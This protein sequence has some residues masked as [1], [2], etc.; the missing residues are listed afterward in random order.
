MVGAKD[1]ETN[2]VAARAIPKVDGEVL[3]DF[4]DSV[5]DPDATVYT[6]GSSAYRRRDNHES[7][8][9]SHGEYVPGRR[10]HE[11]RGVAV[12]DPEASL[13]GNA[14]LDE[15]EAPPAVRQRTL[16]PPQHPETWT[17]STR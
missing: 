4:V 2:Q 7:V 8:S 6:D 16:R 15:S 14:P 13:H 11:R 5:T 12:G 3:L 1:R 9:H 17:P 10:P